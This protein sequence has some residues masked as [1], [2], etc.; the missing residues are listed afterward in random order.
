MKKRILPKVILLTLVIL[1]LLY[2]LFGMFWPGPTFDDSDLRVIREQ[3]P[4]EENAFQYFDQAAAKLVVPEGMKKLQYVLRDKNPD[5]NA[6]KELIDQNEQVF[7]LL[8][9]GLICPYLQVP[10]SRTIH[11]S[12]NKGAWRNVIRLGLLRSEHLFESGDEKEAFELAM[13]IV[14]FG[15]MIEGAGGDWYIYR[16]GSDAK[17]AGLGRIL[18]MLP[19]VFL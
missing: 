1:P 11:Y 10:Q 18:M 8:D 13:K 4:Y 15:H 12:F 9:Q 17:A 3:I 2:V 16:V 6:I 5:Q 14:K 19:D 7:E